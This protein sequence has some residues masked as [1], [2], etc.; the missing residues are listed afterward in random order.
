M[1][2]KT[3]AMLVAEM[4]GTFVLAVVVLSV[5][6]YGL[7]IFTALALQLPSVR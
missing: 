2:K 1:S 3:L 6:R 5:T 4:V 7:P